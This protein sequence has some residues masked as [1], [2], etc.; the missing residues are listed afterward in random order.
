MSLVLALLGCPARR[1]RFLRTVRTWPRHDAPPGLRVLADWTELHRTARSCTASVAVVD[2]YEG[3]AELAY[4]NDFCRNFPSLGVVAYVGPDHCTAPD[5]M[6][7]ARIG[8]VDV[9][10]HGQSDDAASLRET[11]IGALGVAR[12]HCVWTMFDDPVRVRALPILRLLLG[13]A[14]MRLTPADLARACGRHPGSLRRDLQLLG[15][16]SPEKLIV[17]CRLFVAAHLMADPGRTLSDVARAVGVASPANL[18]NQFRRY[19]GRSAT[20]VRTM[21]GLA[22]LLTTFGERYCARDGSVPRRH[23]EPAGVIDGA[24]TAAGSTARLQPVRRSRAVSPTNGS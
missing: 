21:G 5:V 12:L 17:W 23:A 15:L 2:P 3:A 1:A 13:Q 18:S 14:G 4:L 20:G 6:K 8:V 9:V 11:L 22:C 24:S 19:A 16:P 7:L 10:V